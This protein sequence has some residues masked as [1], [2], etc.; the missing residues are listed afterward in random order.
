MPRA[1]TQQH[2]VGK[3]AQSNMIEPNKNNPTSSS[4]S[5][6]STMHSKG[7]A[8]RNVVGG[9]KKS[10]GKEGKE[11]EQRNAVVEGNEEDKKKPEAVHYMLAL[12]VLPTYLGSKVYLL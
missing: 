7:I 4:N 5:K 8:A 10:T 3:K 11:I 2:G 1:E 12:A 6:S 9:E